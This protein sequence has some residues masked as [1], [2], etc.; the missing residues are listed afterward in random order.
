LHGRQM[1]YIL[2]ASLLVQP[3][4]TQQD[5]TADLPPVQVYA[6]ASPHLAQAGAG[7]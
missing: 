4:E 6:M 3:P 1:A 7:G 5:C 2:T